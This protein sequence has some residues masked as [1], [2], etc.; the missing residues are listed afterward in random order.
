MKRLCLAGLMYMGV[1]GQVAVEPEGCVD[2][3]PES[4]A[5]PVMESVEEFD[6]CMDALKGSKCDKV[7]AAYTMPSK[8]TVCGGQG[9][10]SETSTSTIEV[11][12]TST[13]TPP[14][15]GTGKGYTSRVGSSSGEAPYATLVLPAFPRASTLL[16][17]S[18]LTGFENDC[19]GARVSFSN[20]EISDEGEVGITTD[21]VE[22]DAG[23]AT[24]EWVYYPTEGRVLVLLKNGKQCTDME[25][26]GA[27]IITIEGR[28]NS[29][30]PLFACLVG[31][32]MY[33][34]L[35]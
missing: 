28:P 2:T 1:A 13:G 25:K 24:E 29:A 5:S 21:L 7:G 11:T 14:S 12:T 32:M 35:F 31:A 34:L 17:I 4:C 33:I 6:Q 15:T 19:A 3:L 26:D 18:S 20:T 30:L 8:W 9:K 10:G 22:S 23:A 16:L 27:L